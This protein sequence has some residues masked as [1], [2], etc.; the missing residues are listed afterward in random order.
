MTGKKCNYDRCYINQERK[1]LNLEHPNRRKLHVHRTYIVT[2]TTA[3]DGPLRS[4]NSSRH[5]MI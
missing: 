4:E 3:T 5:D 1:N 2:H